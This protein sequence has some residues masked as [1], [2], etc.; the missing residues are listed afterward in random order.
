MPTTVRCWIVQLNPVQQPIKAYGT[1]PIGVFEG[2]T[3]ECPQRGV[4]QSLTFSREGYLRPAAGIHL[5]DWLVDQKLAFVS[6]EP[7]AAQ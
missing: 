6:T 2:L 1:V 4:K 7:A 3:I 5:H